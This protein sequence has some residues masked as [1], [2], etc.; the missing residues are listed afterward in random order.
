MP[1]RGTLLAGA[2][3]G[4]VLVQPTA[5]CNVPVFRYALERWPADPY[6]V[7]VLHDGPLT[8]AERV[9]LDQLKGSSS[10]NVTFRAVDLRQQPER[11][12]PPGLPWLEVRYPA[13][14]RI[15][16][17][18][19][20]GRLNEA[21]VRTLLDSPAR[22]ELA[23]RILRGDSAVWLLLESGKQKDDEAAVALLQTRLKAM[24]ETLKL[25]ERTDAP[26][27]RVAIEDELPVRLAFS[28]IRLR[29][30]DPKE[31]LFVRMLLGTEPDLAG[32]VEPM[33]FPVFGRARVLYALVGAGITGDNLE[34]AA[35]Y[36]IGACS[37]EVKRQNPG[38]DLLT[39]TDWDAA[40]PPTRQPD[41]PPLVGLSSFLPGAE[42][43]AR[44]DS[45]APPEPVSSRDLML[46]AALVAGLLVALT[47]WLAG[48]RR[49]R[50]GK[51]SY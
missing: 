1:R 28:M 2:L 29:R 51:G 16:E 26:A 22:R 10:A 18:M 15:K 47:L 34:E 31:G 39:A 40:L 11:D 21:V 25:P 44:V 33:V 38:V 7:V 41:L 42:D 49:A 36:V 50:A 30:D 35:R 32:Y 19:W 46:V 24:Q 20:T 4:L 12:R 5:A 6:E 9:L 37:C 3:L 8:S 14:V 17:P 27:D 45:D 23:A 43:A 13:A 48:Y